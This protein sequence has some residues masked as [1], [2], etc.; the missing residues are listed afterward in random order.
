MIGRKSLKGSRNKTAVLAI[1]TAVFFSIAALFAG[2]VSAWDADEPFLR[3]A[4]SDRYVTA[5]EVA[6]AARNLPGGTPGAVILA[7]GDE[8]GNFA[9]GLAAGVLAGVHNAPVL[10]T[11]PDK[12]P[13]CVSE[14]LL[15]LDAPTVYL[16]GGEAAI[17]PEIEEELKGD[18]FIVKR[19]QGK[20]RYDTA[21]AIA[22]S[23]EGKLSRTAYI[24]N[25]TA[26]ADSL[27]AGPIA[28]QNNSAILH[29]LADRIPEATL[30][31][32][33]ELRIDEVVIVGGETVV[34][35]AVEDELEE[36]VGRRD[37][38]RVAGA[39][40]IATSLE[41]ARQEA[42]RAESV[43]FIG[44]HNIADGLAAS[45]LGYLLEAPVIY[46]AK[47]RVHES[48]SE[49]LVD[50]EITKAVFL[51]GTEAISEKVALEVKKKIT[52][53]SGD[54]ED[55]QTPQTRPHHPYYLVKDGNLFG[56]DYWHNDVY[57]TEAPDFLEPG[58]YYVVD[59]DY[60]FF[61]WTPDGT[62]EKPVGKFDYRVEIPYLLFNLNIPAPEE[63]TAK[64]LKKLIKEQN[65]STP[66]KDISGA[67]I[68]AQNTW[69]VN[70]IY[71]VAHAALESG[72]GKSAIAQDKNNLFGFRAYDDNPYQHAA[73]FECMED[74]ILYV[75]GYIKKQYLVDGG[76]YFH[77]SDLA[78]MNVRYA[79]DP[80]WAVKIARIIERLYPYDKAD[81]PSKYEPTGYGAVYI[82]SWLENPDI[83]LN[84][85]DKPSTDGK[86]IESLT[87]GQVVK[88]LDEEYNSKE[89]RTWYKVRLPETEQEGWVAGEYLL[90][91]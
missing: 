88:I 75:S 22:T 10:L 25:G 64:K 58:N 46:I 1:L 30:E 40:R 74:C 55:P 56:R 89:G 38:S 83:T 86:K 45:F 62:E 35:K 66:L 79:S 13:A 47:D 39:D 52:G 23:V 31:A 91:Q 69:G 60:N 53:A 68:E 37:V 49:Y 3:L 27:A 41:L 8:A 42:G 73:E 54:D 2:I 17:S 67:F 19:L 9:D 7:R 82:S 61:R 48:V 11:A 26:P 28:A 15:E 43:L 59:G 44:A 80:M 65:S 33:D 85:R 57:L 81:Y 5:V 50:E 36:I 12:L 29:V 87:F 76:K 24:V 71:L 34:S 18:G 84:M 32:L 72:W 51:G 77:G 4:G 63:V 21:K 16:L 90:L 20:D 6:K 78:G 70:A 14:A